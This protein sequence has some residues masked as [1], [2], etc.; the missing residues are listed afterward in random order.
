MA[1]EEKVENPEAVLAELRR[2]QADLKELRAEN[3]TLKAERDTLQ[4][5]VDSLS[6]DEMR[7]KALKAE[8][9]LAL[10]AQ[11]IKDVDRLMPYI[12]TEGLDFDDKGAVSGLEDRLKTLKKDLPEVFDPKVRAGGRADIF[13]NDSAEVR[14]D[15]FKHAVRQALNPS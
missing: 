2:A 15:P 5:S 7:V 8:T 1:E 3:K 13:A 10:Q 11:G 6:T 9:K 4:A 12:G 14:E